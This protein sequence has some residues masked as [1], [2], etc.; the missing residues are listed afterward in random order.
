[1]TG[2]VLDRAD[3]LVGTGRKVTLPLPLQGNVS[4]VGIS[5]LTPNLRSVMGR[6]GSPLNLTSIF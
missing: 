4:V 5:A 6:D 1:V 3:A 2:I